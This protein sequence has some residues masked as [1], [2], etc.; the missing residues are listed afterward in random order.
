MTSRIRT[1]ISRAKE[2][3]QEEGLLTLIKRT[4]AFAKYTVLS[5]ASYEN[6]EFYITGRVFRVEDETKYLPKITNITHKIVETVTQLDELQKDGFD[7]SLLD[8][9][10][11]KHRLQ[12]GAIAILVFVSH[13]LGFKSWTAL[14]KEA[15][16]IINPYPYKV[17]FENGEVCGGNAWTNPKYR[18]QGLNTFAGHK[19]EQYLIGKGKTKSRSIKYTTNIA[20]IGVTK[21][22]GS[23][24]IAK[25]RY[26]RIFGL[27]FWRE[28]PVKSEGELPR[29]E[30]GKDG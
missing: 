17:D 6:T 27:K 24:I 11:P 16:D 7:L 13:E 28:K 12:K 2:I 21:K 5:V 29:T 9:D 30:L 25:A 10:Q 14:T 23:S 20:S 4:F 18:R 8:V 15:K 22:R 1:L 19:R 3:Y 26:I